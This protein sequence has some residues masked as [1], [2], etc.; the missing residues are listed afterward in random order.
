ME[1]QTR[2]FQRGDTLVVLGLEYASFIANDGIIGLKGFMVRKYGE[3]PN[4]KIG[5]VCQYE[6]HSTY[7]RSYYSNLATTRMVL[8]EKW[9][10]RISHIFAKL[11][12]FRQA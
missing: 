1:R 9:N 11:K 12:D 8:T 4:T 6:L 3:I 2:K 5:N 10:P 7:G